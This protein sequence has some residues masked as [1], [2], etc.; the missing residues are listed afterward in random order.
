[1]VV[2]SCTPGWGV[3]TYCFP[4]VPMSLQVQCDRTSSAEFKIFGYTRRTALGNALTC[5]CPHLD[6][7]RGKIAR[8]FTSS[9]GRVSNDPETL[10]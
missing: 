9:C 1:M 7:P 8:G 10:R 4:T 5:P 2:A 6:Q 3:N